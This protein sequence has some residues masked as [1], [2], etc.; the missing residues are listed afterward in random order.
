MDPISPAGTVSSIRALLQVPAA[1]QR[2]PLVFCAAPCGNRCRDVP[3][4]NEESVVGRGG[5]SRE[6]AGGQE[7]EAL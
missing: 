3:G 6:R 1:Q 7:V 2:A 5:S 4:E